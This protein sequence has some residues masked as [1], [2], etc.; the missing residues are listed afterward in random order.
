MSRRTVTHLLTAVDTLSREGA[1]H[2]VIVRK[3]QKS[4][5][6]FRRLR[7]QE[8]PISDQEWQ[9]ILLCALDLLQSRTDQERV[10]RS[11]IEREIRVCVA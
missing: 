5:R 3:L 8:K 9:G 7:E 1:T 10:A 6:N 11:V 4:L 2:E